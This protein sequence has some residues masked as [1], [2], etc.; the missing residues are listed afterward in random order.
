MKALVNVVILQLILQLNFLKKDELNMHGVE[1]YYS[2]LNFPGINKSTCCRYDLLL[3]NKSD[4]IN[5]CLNMID[6]L[7]DQFDTLINKPK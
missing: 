5:D 6:I 3:A 1:F 7:L 2:D 4:H